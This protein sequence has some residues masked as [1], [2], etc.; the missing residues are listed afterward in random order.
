[1]EK[2]Q[3]IFWELEKSILKNDYYGGNEKY[4]RDCFGFELNFKNILEFYLNSSSFVIK[5]NIQNYYSGYWN[6]EDITKKD[7]LWMSSQMDQALLHPFERVKRTFMDLP[8]GKFEPYLYK[9]SF[10]RPIKLMISSDNN[11]NNILGGFDNYFYGSFNK[12]INDKDKNKEYTHSINEFRV[13][14]REVFVNINKTCYKEEERQFKIQNNY[15]ILQFIKAINMIIDNYYPHI[16]KIDGYINEFDQQEIAVIDFNKL[17]DQT[18]LKSSKILNLESSNNKT[19]NFPINDFVKELDD[20]KDKGE[21][22]IADVISNH[23]RYAYI[24]KVSNS[25]KDKYLMIAK[26]GIKIN[27]QDF[28]DNSKILLYEGTSSDELFTIDSLLSTER[29]INRPSIIW[30]NKYLKYK[31]KYLALKKQM[32][33]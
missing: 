13:A 29:E 30:K 16:E 23:I 15:K 12:F 19:Y 24:P 18:S 25:D 1:M 28:D 21:T 8:H 2:V 31:N 7:F 10:N 14:F 33:K 6:P 3:C 22:D 5:P 32:N 20:S 17:L 27:Y 4:D 11:N 9:F 26:N